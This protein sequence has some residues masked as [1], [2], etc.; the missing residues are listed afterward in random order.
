MRIRP[1]LSKLLSASLL[2]GILASSSLA[3]T[4]ITSLI[5]GPAPAPTAAPEPSPTPQPPPAGSLAPAER[6]KFFVILQS[7]NSGVLDRF[8]PVREHLEGLGYPVDI[9]LNPSAYGDVDLI[10]FGDMACYDAID[11]LKAVL[12][13]KLKID[14]L[15]RVRF[16]PSD[17][18]YN[19][20]SIVIQIKS[21]D[22][23][24]PNL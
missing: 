1:C 24:D 18:R 5:A 6:A 16:D 22:L 23:F 7:N 11:D 13:G 4:T 20:T 3:C 12:A 21:I 15:T 14:H 19:S 10:L 9:L 2:L 17:L 8:Y